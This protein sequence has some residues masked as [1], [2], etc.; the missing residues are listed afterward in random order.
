MVA[1]R[2]FGRGDVAFFDGVARAYDLI[3]PPSSTAELRAAF[4]R[5]TR[6]VDRVLD[7]AGGTG[8]VSR[9]LRRDGYDPLVVDV[10]RGMVSRA[11][12]HGLS[13]VQA[14]AGR[15]PLATGSVD[16]AVVVDAY[17]HLPDRQAALAETARVVAP[18]GAVVVRDFDPTTLPGRGLEAAEHL[19]GMGS[20]F[21]SADEVAAAL[22]RAGLRSRVL[23]RG[24]VATVVG[25]VPDET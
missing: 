23:E 12:G 9:T 4:D 6:P 13:A 21:A 5:A 16:A 19:L 22:S 10:S 11:R 18:G 20:R 1:R 8:R 2:P 7:L 17:H 3:V 14:D 25:V 15:L 24:F